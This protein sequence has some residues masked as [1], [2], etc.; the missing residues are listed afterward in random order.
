[1]EVNENINFFEYVFK[2]FFSYR[3]SVQLVKKVNF[4]VCPIALFIFPFLFYTNALFNTV[5]VFI[6]VW[7]LK[8]YFNL[9]FFFFIQKQEIDCFL[10]LFLSEIVFVEEFFLLI[11]FF[12]FLKN[13]F[14]Y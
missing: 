2:I 8:I 12:L 1:M 11:F 3:N 13:Y 9:F 7:R 10:S 14:F 5:V 4:A 6:Q